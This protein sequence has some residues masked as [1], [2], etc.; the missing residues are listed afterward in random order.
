MMTVTSVEAQSRFGYLLD[1]AQREPVIITRHG[2]PAACMISPQDLKA[3]Q[4]ARAQGDQGRDWA[5]ASAQAWNEFDA[6]F[7]AFADEYSTL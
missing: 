1:N 4:Q 6:R 5:A 2:R 7:G 3:L